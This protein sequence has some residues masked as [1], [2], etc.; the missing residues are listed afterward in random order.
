MLQEAWEELQRSCVKPLSS[1]GTERQSLAAEPEPAFIL[2]F[3]LLGGGS[4]ECMCST[5]LSIAYVKSALSTSTE[6]PDT[7]NFRLIYAGQV[8]EDDKFLTD[9]M[10]PKAEAVIH[11]V[12][13]LRGCWGLP[14][15]S[16]ITQ[17]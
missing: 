1:S 12:L 11:V 16:K 17:Q 15:T 4:L 2:I 5:D 9:Y 14:S 13:R 6:F 8:L 3:K 7:T 10:K